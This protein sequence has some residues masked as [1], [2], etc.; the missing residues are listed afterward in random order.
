MW[1]IQKFWDRNH[2]SNQ[3]ALR[4]PWTKLPSR[5]LSFSSYAHPA[6]FVQM[7]TF[8]EAITSCNTFFGKTH[9][10]AASLKISSM[11]KDKTAQ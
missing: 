6:V 3:T 2:I 9:K 1:Q 4:I 11:E 10:P 5:V 7:F 8:L